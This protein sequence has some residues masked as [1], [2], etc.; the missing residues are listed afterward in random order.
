MD[1]HTCERCAQPL[2]IHHLEP[3]RMYVIELPEFSDAA[4]IDACDRHLRYAMA[5]VSADQ[6]PIIILTLHGFDVARVPEVGADTAQNEEVW[7]GKE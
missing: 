2:T 4:M 6:R 1:I 7:H 5:D 3:G